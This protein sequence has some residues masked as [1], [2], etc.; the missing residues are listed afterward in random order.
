VFGKNGGV[1]YFVEIVERTLRKVTKKN[2]G[3]VGD[4]S[5]NF[6][7]SSDRSCSKALLHHL[8]LIAENEC[9]VAVSND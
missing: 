2:R 9:S 3:S 1:L 4:N 6:L 8:Q 5:G 7:R